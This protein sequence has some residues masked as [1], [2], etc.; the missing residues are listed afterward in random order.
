LAGASPVKEEQFL[1]Q[2]LLQS[3]S[4]AV[5]KKK[6]EGLR[7]LRCLTFAMSGLERVVVQSV[8]NRS[9]LSRLDYRALG[10]F[11]QAGGKARPVLGGQLGRS[12]K[13]P[14]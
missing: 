14:V 1:I 12:W 2:K 3:F 5:G 4:R 10:G 13:V 7:M 9:R 11:Y 8:R 6:R